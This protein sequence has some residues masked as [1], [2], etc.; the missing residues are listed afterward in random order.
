MFPT[1]F[2]FASA[3]SLPLLTLRKL[4]VTAANQVA[5][6]KRSNENHLARR[7]PGLSLPTR[8]N[9]GRQEFNIGLP[10]L[11]RGI[12]VDCGIRRGHAKG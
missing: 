4:V 9:Q 11:Y 12:Y 5:A 10:C 7:L 3:F 6:D 8:I 1:P 2:S